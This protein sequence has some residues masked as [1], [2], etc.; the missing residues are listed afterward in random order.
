MQP[1]MLGAV[2]LTA[3]LL[4]CQSSLADGLIL[5]GVSAQTIGR[6]GTNI[7]HTDN[8]SILHDNPAAMTMMDTPSLFSVGGTVL[9]TD[10][11]YS[12]PDNARQTQNRGYPLGELAFIR[13]S[14]DEQFAFGFGVF[15][16]AG[17]GSQYHLQPPAPFSGPTLYKSFGALMK[18]LPG[19]AFKPT[20]RLSIGAT[21]GL[22]VTIADLE[23]P[24]VLQQTPG[25]AGTP[26]MLDMDVDGAAFVWSFGIMYEL[27]ESTRIGATY[28]SESRFHADGRTL[29]TVPGLGQSFYDTQMSITWPQS[30]G[31]G[32]RHEL[33][34]HRIVSA[35]VIWF[36][37]S[38]AF[39]SFGIQ[40]TNPSNPYFPEFSDEFPL[41]WR[42][43]VS[44]RLGFEQRFCCDRVLRLGY[45]YHR[46]PVPTGTA[47]PYIPASLQQSFSV[48][49]GWKMW[50]WESNLA[51]M[52][53]FG[54]EV[55]VGTSDFVGGDFDNSEQR[56]QTHAVAV[57]F[58]QRF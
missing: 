12:D 51:Y 11:D 41:D 42:D 54:P 22:G 37:W 52:Y 1:R 39:D 13:R 19:I 24:Y 58:Q 15:S 34:P 35:D 30:V 32:V 57:S 29:G 31:L 9:I 49:Y 18:I 46:S 8:G 47:S 44:V 38:G 26:T 6:G 16:P 55:H 2:T 43:T 28:Q 56:A 33:C 21:A 20:D 36:D 7:A 40:M 27:S 53:T 3:F 45:V 50:G 14:C 25:L 5:N 4:T 17:F 10:F 23:G 48:G